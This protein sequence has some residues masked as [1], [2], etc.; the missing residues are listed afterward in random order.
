MLIYAMTSVHRKQSRA[1][2]RLLPGQ[3]SYL[4]NRTECS[5]RDLLRTNISDGCFDHLVLILSTD[6]RKA[7]V[8][9]LIVSGPKRNDLNSYVPRH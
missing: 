3:I 9:A 1:I 2:E 6:T 7:Q 4:K 8:E 5:E